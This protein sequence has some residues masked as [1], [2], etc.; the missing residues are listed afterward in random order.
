[1]K[2]G[3][4][5]CSIGHAWKLPFEP[6]L[7][8]I[9]ADDDVAVTKNNNEGMVSLAWL[10]SMHHF[11]FGQ[12]NSPIGIANGDLFACWPFRPIV[13][14][15]LQRIENSLSSQIDVRSAIHCGDVRESCCALWLVKK[16]RGRGKEKVSPLLNHAGSMAP[17]PRSLLE[18][19]DL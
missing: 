17:D 8:K 5:T 10:R 3:G 15:C 16:E 14:R 1:M 2:D 12:R 13:C 6:F 4:C 9:F 11:P 7:E 19:L 18:R